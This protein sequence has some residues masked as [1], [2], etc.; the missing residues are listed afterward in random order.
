MNE[1]MSSPEQAL[2]RKS[3]DS[4]TH[5]F[6]Y[7]CGGS[8][9][10]ACTKDNLISVTSVESDLAWIQKVVDTCQASKLKTIHTNIGPTK[11]WGFPISKPNQ[12]W[13]HYSKA[14]DQRH[15]ETNLVL[16]DGR[17]RVACAA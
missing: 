3:L 14:F 5:Y 13:E 12:S 4:A 7:G 6:E 16:I 1:R 17:F 15:P 11:A 2:F 8:T 10:Q 9:W